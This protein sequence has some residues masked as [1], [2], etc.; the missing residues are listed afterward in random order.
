MNLGENMVARRRRFTLQWHEG[1]QAAGAESSPEIEATHSKDVE[2]LDAY[3]R[4]IVAVVQRVGPAVVSIQNGSAAQQKQR[5]ALGLGSGVVISPQGLIVTSTQVVHD[6]S[7]ITVR[8]PDGVMLAAEVIGLDP[9]TDIALLSVARD[10]AAHATLADSATL[11]I[12]QT[13]IA[14]GNPL[15]Y[16]SMVSTGVIST[17]GRSLRSRAG[18]L[19]EGLVQHTANI[20]PGVPGGVL[21]DPKGNLVGLLTE[22]VALGKIDFFAIPSNVAAWVVPQ[23]R[24]R[25]YVR[26]GR[27]GVSG[28]ARPLEPS[29]Q[30]EHE[31]QQSSGIEVLAVEAKGPAHTGGLRQG[32]YIVHLNNQKCQN[33][34]ELHRYLAEWPLRRPLRVTIL[35][36]QEKLDLE[37]LPVEYG[38]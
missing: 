36:G 29:I 27:I 19:L 1:K 32:D 9:A 31:L 6:S 38:S 14:V 28:E 17:L 26:R 11:Q 33:L 20:S 22:C 23:L 5:E 35:R 37:V 24:A 15:G 16:Q 7:E 3:S 4:A 30:K 25:G 2:M 21:L 12:G 34:E 18:K 13:V 8:F 10:H